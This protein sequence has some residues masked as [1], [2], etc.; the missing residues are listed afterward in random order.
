[1]SEGT[2]SDIA[3]YSI[4]N[5]QI[6]S[7]YLNM[8]LSTPMAKSAKF[9]GAKNW[10]QLNETSSLWLYK[11]DPHIID[12]YSYFH[13]AFS[14]L[15]KTKINIWGRLSNC[16]QINIPH[17]DNPFSWSYQPNNYLKKLPK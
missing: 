15:I 14:Y 17:L 3:A 2:F 9:H 1:M 6:S 16:H 11:N 5:Y 8:F 7:K 13:L 4:L 10:S 12:N